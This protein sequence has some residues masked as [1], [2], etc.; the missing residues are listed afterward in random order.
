MVVS[1]GMLQALNNWKP[2][3]DDGD[4]RDAIFSQMVTKKSLALICSFLL[5]FDPTT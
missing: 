2:Y 5:H 3:V 4:D 1:G